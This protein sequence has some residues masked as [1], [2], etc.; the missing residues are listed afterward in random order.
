MIDDAKSQVDRRKLVKKCILSESLVVGFG[1]FGLPE[2][3]LPAWGWN[4]WLAALLFERF[5]KEMAPLNCGCAYAF[6]LRFR[7]LSSATG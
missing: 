2:S 7:V 1:G 4:I 6:G 5:V 3:A